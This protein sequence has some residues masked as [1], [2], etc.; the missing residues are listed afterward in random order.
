M[1]SGGAGFTIESVGIII[2]AAVVFGGLD[3]IR[4]PSW[5]HSSSG[6]SR[7][8]GATTRPRSSVQGP[9]DHSP[10]C[11]CWS[12]S[13]SNRAACSVRNASR[14]SNNAHE[15]SRFDRRTTDDQSRYQLTMH[16]RHLGSTDVQRTTNHGIKGGP[17]LAVSTSPATKTVWG[18]SAGVSSA[19][20]WSSPSPIPFLA[21]LAVQG[22]L[23]STITQIYIFAIAVLGLNVILGY[24]GEIVLAR[25]RSWLSGRTRRVRYLR[26]ACSVSRS[27]CFRRSWSVV[28]SPHSSRYCS[29]S[30]RSA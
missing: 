9:G 24:A 27:A 19:L 1:A 12:S 22:G 29:E 3:S 21:P 15:T 4:G 17:C 25:G 2:F 30:H 5:E 16:T 18:C 26:T 28:S 20:R 14:G 7:S 10:W 8:T 23:L 11:S 13:S 6:F